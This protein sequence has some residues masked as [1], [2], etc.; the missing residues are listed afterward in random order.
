MRS[1]QCTYGQ[2]YHFAHPLLPEDL[3]VTAHRIETALAEAA[4][5]AAEAEAQA[6]VEAASRAGAPA[7]HGIVPQAAPA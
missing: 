3:P 5:A 7:G 4:E 1:L 6:E 2:G